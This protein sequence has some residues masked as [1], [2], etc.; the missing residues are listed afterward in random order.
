MERVMCR[1]ALHVKQ[2]DFGQQD[3]SFEYLRLL[4]TKPWHSMLWAGAEK[5]ASETV[6]V[7][8]DMRPERA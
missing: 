2:L 5:L 1:R 3:V 7:M 8:I 6:I 4:L